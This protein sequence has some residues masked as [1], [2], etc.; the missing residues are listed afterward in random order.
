MFF[1]IIL[2]KLFGFSLV[3]GFVTLLSLVL[4]Y[5]KVDEA[6]DHDISNLKQNID[7][8]ANRVLSKLDIV[9]IINNRS[10]DVK[11]LKIS[12]IDGNK[13]LVMT[14]DKKKISDLR[15][16]ADELLYNLKQSLT[17]DEKLYLITLMAENAI[18]EQ[19]E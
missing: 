2:K 10:V 17:K 18:K 12:T 4:T 5:K 3:G 8:F 7:L 16:K 6:F 1:R 13:N 15:E 11:K 19:D 14:V 9:E